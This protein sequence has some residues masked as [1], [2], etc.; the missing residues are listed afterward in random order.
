[1]QA[2]RPIQFI[3]DDGIRRPLSRLRFLDSGSNAWYHALQTSLRKE[4]THG[5]LFTASYSYSYAAMESYGRNEGDGINSQ[6]YQ[7]P[8]DRAA[9]KGRIGFNARHI[10]ALSFVYD[11]PAPLAIS[12]GV[13]GAVFSGWQTNG[14]L[15]FRTGLPFSVTEGNIINT[16]N[17]TV[18]PDRVGT[19]KL[20]N[21]NINQWF[22]P[23]AFHIVS[24]ASSVI[25]EACHYGTAGNSILEGPGG[26]IVDFSAFKNFGIT[27]RFKLQFRAEFFNFLNTPQFG[28]PQR[29]MNTGGGFQP[30]RTGGQ[31]VYP[32]Q[33]NIVGGVGAVTTLASPMRNIQFG[34]KLLW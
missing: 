1:M 6:T 24:C 33:A 5:F 28:V 19:G 23:D 31:I 8:R 29:N 10:A 25:P 7:N 22:N 14:I 20:D 11:V 18:R 30:T 4:M 15:N 2:R 13:A 21:Q 16:A 32:S 34:L 27:E 12:K 3:I 17:S 9:E 26:S